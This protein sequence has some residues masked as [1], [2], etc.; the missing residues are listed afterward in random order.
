[1]DVVNGRTRALARRTVLLGVAAGGLAPLTAC[2]RQRTATRGEEAGA[3]GSVAPQG[4][5]LAAPR[6]AVTPA[7]G[8]SGGARVD[9][10][11]GLRLVLPDGARALVPER[12]HGGG[13]S[14][15]YVW[16]RT[17]SW[18]YLVVE[19][20][21]ALEDAEDAE[22][23][24]LGHVHAEQQRLISAGVRPSAPE[25]AAWPGF[26]AAAVLTWNQ[27]TTPPGW[28]APTSV[29]ALELVLSAGG[30]QGCVLVAY[31]PRDGLVTGSPA[32][33][34]LCSVTAAS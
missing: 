32:L 13:A 25:G 26:E 19:G 23:A 17:D 21:V 3:P 33:A 20:P 11:S 5:S 8:G 29:D 10:V 31:G 6:V 12:A 14:V 22:D 4:E 1:M 18:G 7:A 9:P 16:D 34:A 15:V 2:T 28:S 30:G 24:A 27:R